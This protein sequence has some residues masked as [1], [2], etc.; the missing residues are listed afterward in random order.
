MYVT[1][2]EE[3]I[4]I[5]GTFGQGTIYAE[6]NQIVRAF[7]RPTDKFDD[8]KC[9]AEWHVRFDNGT[10]ASIYNWKNG[11]NYLGEDG[12]P[13][14]NITHWSI[15]GSSSSAVQLVKQA[16]QTDRQHVDMG[17]SSA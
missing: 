11:Q 1:H 2:N 10:V 8:Y 4:D 17:T 9:D 12:T 15:G 13:T 14:R 5:N 16:I 6:Y 3:P 7:G